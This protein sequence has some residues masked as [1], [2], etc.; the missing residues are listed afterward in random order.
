MG[1]CISKFQ[2][3]LSCGTTRTHSGN[4]TLKVVSAIKKTMPTVFR[5]IANQFTY[6]IIYVKDYRRTQK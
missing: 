6:E 4:R 2:H 1:Q 5:N 3:S